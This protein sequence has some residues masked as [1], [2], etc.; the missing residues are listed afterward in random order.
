MLSNPFQGKSRRRA[1]M[2]V[3]SKLSMGYS[4]CWWVLQHLFSNC[5]FVCYG[6]VKLVKA[7]PVGC[8]S[9]MMWG[10]SLSTGAL[11]DEV[12]FW[13][14]IFPPQKEARS[15]GFPPSCK[16][17]GWNLGFIDRVC[18]SFLC[19]FWCW[20]FLSCPLHRGYSTNFWISLRG[21]W[22]IHV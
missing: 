21:Y 2:S 14:K 6:L 7:N 3:P 18:I 22:L 1:F 16:V 20:Y 8:W 17:L 11:K 13:S 5:F 19:Q 15:S 12:I 9:W 4:R 10:F